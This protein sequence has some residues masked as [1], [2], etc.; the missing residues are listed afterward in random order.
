MLNES[1]LEQRNAI[2]YVAIQT[3]VSVPFGEVLGPLW[4]EVFGWLR[5]QGIEPAGPPFIRYITIDMPK[6]LALEVGVPVASA[7]TGNDRISAGTFPAG[8][9][10]VALYT[11]DYSGLQKATAELLAWAEKQKIVFKTTGSGK[12]EVWAARYESYIADPKEEPNPEKWQTQLVF[13]VR[14]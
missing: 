13:L 5:S 4:G 14:E 6:E 2:P 3:K 10:A 9:Y 1:K 7:V 8:R 12:D 11:G